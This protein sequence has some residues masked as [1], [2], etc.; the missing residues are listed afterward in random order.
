MHSNLRFSVRNLP[1]AQPNFHTAGLGA[2]VADL[3][4]KDKTWLVLRWAIAVK[5]QIR[6][7]IASTISSRSSICGRFRERIDSSDISCILYFHLLSLVS[8]QCW[9]MRSCWACFFVFLMLF[10]N[11]AFPAFTKGIVTVQ[12]RHHTVQ[13]H[14]QTALQDAVLIPSIRRFCALVS[15]CDMQRSA[16]SCASECLP[17][18]R[19][20][21]HASPNIAMCAVD[22][23]S[24]S[25]SGGSYFIMIPLLAI[26]WFFLTTTALHSYDLCTEYNAICSHYSGI[27]CPTRDAWCCRKHYGPTSSDL[28]L[29]HARLADPIGYFHHIQVGV[30]FSVRLHLAQRQRS[31]ATTV[32]PFQLKFIDFVSASRFITFYALRSTT[33]SEGQV[34]TSAAQL[35]CVSTGANLFTIY[36]VFEKI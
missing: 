4:G 14:K 23:P 16:R 30:P 12:K 26:R 32:L 27:A 34:T 21:A 11:T 29:F 13:G 5:D 15:V 3:S 17:V 33:A 6:T 25:V 36:S 8:K 9:N 35:E 31:H 22:S 18:F 24:W 2:L 7:Q 19:L 10:V 28:R 1:P 20:T